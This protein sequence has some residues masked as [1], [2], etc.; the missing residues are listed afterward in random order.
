MKSNRFLESLNYDLLYIPTC[1][2]SKSSLFIFPSLSYI[3]SLVWSLELIY[4]GFF[5]SIFQ[6]LDLSHVIFSVYWAFIIFIQLPISKFNFFSSDHIA[7]I[8]TEPDPSIY[9]SDFILIAALTPSLLRLHFTTSHI[10]LL[11]FPF[12]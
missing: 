8:L 12:K 7:Q 2:S 4:H 10:L 5:Y 11:K 3:S 6:F 9:L 1:F